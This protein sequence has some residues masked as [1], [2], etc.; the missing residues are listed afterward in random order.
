M[1]IHLTRPLRLAV[2]TTASAVVAAALV[3]APA[4]AEPAGAPPGAP[5]GKPLT[6]MTRNLY[7]GGDINRPLRDTAGK[8]GAAALVA[9]GNSN[10]ALRGVV[11]ATNFPARSKL[12]AAEIAS[13]RPDVVGLQEV[14]LWRSGILELG[15]IGAANAATVDDDFLAT[16]TA[17]LAA[18]GAQ[19]RVVNVQ[20]ESDVEGPAFRGNPFLG[21]MT[22]PRD[23]RLTMRDAMLVRVDPGLTVQASGGGQY[24]TKLP[25]N[26]GGV[27]FVFIRGYNWADLRVGSQVVRVVNTHLESASSDIALGQAAELVAGPARSS[28]PT[29]VV[30]DCNSDPL[31][32]S[33][34]PTDPLGTPHSGPYD[35]IVSRGFTDEWLTWRPAADGWTSGLSEGIRDTT[36][37]GF[38]HRIDLVLARGTGVA[39]VGADRGTV[40]GNDLADRDP[41]TGLW[42]SDHA[43]V[44]L[45]LRGLR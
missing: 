13:E 14:A 3:A 16:L 34:K 44:V 24:A 31:D 11:D 6:L 27:P 9:F 43:G 36:A 4:T 23:V 12:L 38:D 1:S 25:V 33:V 5:P 42:P 10:D 39:T 35:L 19:Y 21:T 17:D 20:Q 41:S 37:A 26:V 29:V 7:L 2:A 40:V 8:T 15:A 18:T 32:H 45:R 28:N 30:C 22:N